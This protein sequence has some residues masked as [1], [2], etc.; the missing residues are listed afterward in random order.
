MAKFDLPAMVAYALRETNQKQ[1]YYVGHSQGTMMIF[2]GLDGNRVLQDRIKTVFALAPV[3]RLANVY[4]PIK[5][6]ATF[7]DIFA[8]V[9]KVV[10]FKCFLPSSKAIKEIGE[11]VCSDQEFCIILI[12]LIA[13]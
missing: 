4:S 8:A 7:E 12:N 1:L 5:Y 6:L 10:R 13:G 2:A 9:L 11:F 3:T